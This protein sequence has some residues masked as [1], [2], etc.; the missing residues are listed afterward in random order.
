M[1]KLFNK[2][3]KLNKVIS[4]WLVFVMLAVPFFSDSGI[5]GGSKAEEGTALTS[6]MK[7]SN[8]IILNNSTELEVK[9]DARGVVTGVSLEPID[10]ASISTIYCA[11]I[12][13]LTLASVGI[14]NMNTATAQITDDDGKIYS[15]VIAQ[16]G[17]ENGGSYKVRLIDSDEL[18]SSPLYYD[19]D[20]SDL[21]NIS[22]LDKVTASKYL[23]VYYMPAVTVN[24]GTD[25]EEFPY[26]QY[27]LQSICKFATKEYNSDSSTG[28]Y[29]QSGGSSVDAT[30]WY[31]AADLHMNVTEGYLTGGTW[32]E[33]YFG[34]FKYSYATSTNY[35]DCTSWY[36]S[37]NI[38]FPEGSSGT[39]AG[40]I[41]YFTNDGD[42]TP[43]KVYSSNNYICVDT[44]KPV[45]KNVGL[46]YSD[47]WSSFDIENST[48]IDGE[49]VI[50]EEN[51]TKYKYCVQ[52]EKD[53]GSDTTTVELLNN[54]VLTSS[55][56]TETTENSDIYYFD[57]DVTTIAGPATIKVTEE[58]GLSTETSEIKGKL[59]LAD[60]T[61]ADIKFS[62]GENASGTEISTSG[63]GNVITDLKYQLS[64][65]STSYVPLDRIVVAYNNSVEYVA[66]TGL[67]GIQNR[68]TDPTSDVPYYTYSDS[69]SVP[70]D[71]LSNNEKYN[72]VV[73]QVY[74]N[75]DSSPSKIV[76]LADSILYDITDPVFMDKDGNNELVNVYDG[77]IWYNIE[78]PPKEIV[79]DILSGNN[80]NVESDIVQAKYQIDGGTETSLIA[81]DVDKVDNASII[82]TTPSTTKEGSEFTIYAKDAAGNDN[83]F[84]GKY[85]YDAEKPKFL[86]DI[87]LNDPTNGNVTVHTDGNLYAYKTN[88]IVTTVTDNIG[89]R[90]IDVIVADANGTEYGKKIIL[91]NASDN[92][93]AGNIPCMT[94]LQELFRDIGNAPSGKYTITITIKDIADN[95]ETKILDIM[96]DNEA[97]I[98]TNAV[99]QKYDVTTLTWVDVGSPTDKLEGWGQWATW[100]K[101]YYLLPGTE[102]RYAVT[103]TDNMVINDDA[104]YGCCDAV[105]SY[106]LDPDGN[107]TDTEKTYFL[108][109]NKSKLNDNVA[110]NITFNIE[111]M[112]GN[113]KE[114]VSCP[115]D[116]LLTVKQDVSSGVT[117]Y[118]LDDND[119][120]DYTDEEVRKKLEAGTNESY[121]VVV[122]ATSAAPIT[123]NLITLSYDVDGTATPIVGEDYNSSI[124]PANDPTVMD[125]EGRYHYY[126]KFV[127]HSEDNIKFKNLKVYIEDGSG[128]NESKDLTTIFYDQTMPEVYSDDTK[129]S[130]FTLPTGWVKYISD[131]PIYVNS[132]EAGDDLESNVDVAQLLIGD[133]VSALD[134]PYKNGTSATGLIT[135][136][137]SSKTSAGTSVVVYVKD[138]AGNETRIP[139]T[140][141]IDSKIPEVESISVDGNKNITVDSIPLT[142]AP[143]IKAVVK[144]NLT[145]DKAIVNVTYPDG[146]VKSKPVSFAANVDG[147]TK[148]VSYT[149]EKLATTDTGITDGTYKV[150]V[151]CYDLAGNE[152]A[153]MT[154][155]FKIDNTKPIVTS[156]ITAGTVS[157][158]NAYFYK[159]DVSVTLTCNDANIDKNGITVTDNG[160]KVTNL[161]WTKN[162]EGTYSAI[163][164]ASS[165][166]DHVVKIVA[167]D[168]S[169]NEAAPSQ[170]AFKIDKTLPVI[171]TTLNGGIVYN[172]NTGLLY[173]TNNVNLLAQ[174]TD[175]N[176]DVNDL[177]YQ[178]VLTKPDQEPVTNLYTKTSERR[179]TYTEEGEYTIN[180][181][182]VD[183][184]NNQSAIRSVKFRIDKAAPALS[185][186]GVGSG[187]S[188]NSVTVSY[189]MRESFWWDAEGTVTI[190]YRSGDGM[191]ENLL[192][193]ID[194]N[195]TAYETV[196]SRTYSD[197]GVYRV[198][199]VASDRAG[200]T[201]ETTAE[202]TIDREAPVVTLEGPENYAK[203]TEA[204]MISMTVVDDFYLQK[205][206]TI[207]G[208]RTDEA[209]KV[210]NIDFGSVNQA[211][212][213]TSVANTFE[214]DGIYDITITAVDKAGNSDSKSVHFTIDKS[215]P[216]IGDLSYLDGKI[217]TS[218]TWDEDLDELVS[219]LT[220]CDVQM[221]LNGSEYDGSSDIE[222]GSYTLVINAEDELG[223]KATKEVSFVLDTKAPVFIVTGV[224]EDEV[225][226]EEYAISISLQL[227]EDTLTSV[228]LNGKDV[229]FNGNTCSFNVTEK[230]EY[231]LVMTAVDEAGN[232]ASYEIEFKYGEEISYW[233]IW[234]IV[235]AV[236]LLTAIIIVVAKKKKKDK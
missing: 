4:L 156:K 76:K 194:Y 166:T 218:F 15:A 155:S 40:F 228:K 117:L 199:F 118:A 56:A 39:Y 195:P 178:L 30:K 37:P 3:N 54:A 86:T 176:E 63:L 210:N 61:K 19:K 175:V 126:K 73:I 93:L 96:L 219:D 124:E 59:V 226:N 98:V 74:Y 57:Y 111:D 41:G 200:H 157:A 130:S 97:P 29:W 95:T 35:K 103:I 196:V 225:K 205:Q 46:Y 208:T 147:G 145:I 154:K 180:L 14:Q 26:V 78:N 113:K 181:F 227:D 179:F 204:V 27:S 158:K 100:K 6:G 68:D 108:K 85:K 127:I 22:E 161:S 66:L 172:D 212:N 28:L 160:T 62:W 142:G 65:E 34:E 170:V 150:E 110:T 64:I 235:A 203:T 182:A 128:K 216:V 47:D 91:D 201:A 75:G 177:N 17:A 123:G 197:T 168:Y 12:S 67:Y 52:V 13:K 165:E 198:E 206:V 82:V 232:E 102:Y 167:K 101:Y 152:S 36:N 21:K 191:Q 202:F 214:E 116:G 53:N 45:I 146:S 9:K 217:L 79:F 38:S 33:M 231:K 193:T 151:Y 189:G 162:S 215:K 233:W 84:T 134:L 51:K 229:A 188:A 44:K 234:I 207:V 183:K 148:E 58:S 187:S 119:V 8:D 222:D 10:V 70:A 83:T 88:E 1:K 139:F 16:N 7:V 42:T 89:V 114:N 20:S 125:G 80:T 236:V 23:L 192:E 120:I 107:N 153:K 71:W 122:H 72:D 5:L 106:T 18:T 174:V 90:Y 144:D 50:R 223:N 105:D 132:G 141:K 129:I 173:M 94:T 121:Y 87:I 211:G 115:Y 55:V 224:E 186:N 25:E 31:S 213:P 136:T 60:T 171:T 221:L 163:Y 11:D 77:N 209:G 99:L 159:S 43:T 230:G 169:G 109:I 2:N 185:V 32:K 112:V 138:V 133:P 48:P 69:V 164:T 131:V 184:A 104:L 49:I 149:I 81:S 190:Y 24:E 143:V 135:L 137:E 220:V 92:A 140:V